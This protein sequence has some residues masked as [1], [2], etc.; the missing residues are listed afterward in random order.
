MKANFTKTIIDSIG[1]I[2]SIN[3]RYRWGGDG[4]R[5]SDSTSTLKNI[6][7]D[8]LFAS[9]AKTDE[10]ALLKSELA[11]KI[12]ESTNAVEISEGEKQYIDEI[13]QQRSTDIRAF[14]LNML[15]EENQAP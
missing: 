1:R 11:K 10:D 8:I 9:Q 6:V 12:Y 7:V 3:N 13:I 4:N 14:Y 2:V 5:I 15:K